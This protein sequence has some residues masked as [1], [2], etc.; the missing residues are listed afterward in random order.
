MIRRLDAD[1]GHRFPVRP[2]RTEGGAK[3]DRWSWG[4]EIARAFVFGLW[5]LAVV[6]SWAAY[7]TAIEPR[8]ERR[9]DVPRSGIANVAAADD[10]Q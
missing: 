4:R 8:L 1:R 2:Q 7:A 9:G 6:I 3:V 5:V 10:G